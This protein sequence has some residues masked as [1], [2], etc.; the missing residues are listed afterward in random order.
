MSSFCIS[1]DSEYANNLK[2]ESLQKLVDNK[3]VSIGFKDFDIANASSVSSF[4]DILNSDQLVLE[5]ATSEKIEDPS[6]LPKHLEVICEIQDTESHSGSREVNLASEIPIKPSISLQC[7]DKKI[8]PLILSKI[9][10]ESTQEGTMSTSL[11]SYKDFSSSFTPDIQFEIERELLLQQKDAEN[12]AIQEALKSSKT[13]PYFEVRNVV[14]TI[15]LNCRINQRDIA[16][17]AKNSEY[18]P[19]RSSA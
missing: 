9:S 18:N 7:S 14:A 8:E 5:T 3:S 1:A 17:R 12:I 13:Q 15:N 11:K 6:D 19:S 10:S 2:D 4:G 16:L